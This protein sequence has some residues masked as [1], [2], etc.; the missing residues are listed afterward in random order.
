VSGHAPNTVDHGARTRELSNFHRAEAQHAAGQ[1]S[2]KKP[3]VLGGYALAAVPEHAVG[4]DEVGIGREG[5]E[6]SLHVMPVPRLC[7][8]FG[9]AVK[10]GE[11]GAHS[12]SLRA[13]ASSLRLD[14]A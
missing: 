2:A 10:V 8:A 6:K 7:K 4:I 1:L 13:A 14:A 5:L 11:V 3:V 9:Q 12:T